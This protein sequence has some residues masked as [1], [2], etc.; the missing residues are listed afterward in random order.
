MYEAFLKNPCLAAFKNPIPMLHEDFQ[1]D[2]VVSTNTPGFTGFVRKVRLAWIGCS[3]EE[4]PVEH[5]SDLLCRPREGFV[6]AYCQLLKILC[7]QKYYD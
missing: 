3:D 7:W 6:S 2:A 5:C 4:L 1:P